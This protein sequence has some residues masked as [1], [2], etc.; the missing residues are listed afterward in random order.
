MAPPRKALIAVS[1]AHAALY[2]GGHETG[3]YA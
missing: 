2:P 1:S 3:T